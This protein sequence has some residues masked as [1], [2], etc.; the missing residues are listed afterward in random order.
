MAG[1][2]TIPVLLA[3][4][5]C[6]PVYYF[7]RIAVHNTVY[8]EKHE[9]FIRQTYR[10]RCMILGANGP[11]SLVIPVEHK[12]RENSQIGE[13]RI[14]YHTD[15]QRNHWRAI[16]SA[17]GNSPFFP[18]YADDIHDYYTRKWT[19][20]FDYNQEYLLT[21]LTLLKLHKELILTGSFEEVPEPFVNLREKISPK[22]P[23][24]RWSPGYSFLPYTQVFNDK[25]PF[26]GELSILDLLFNE[27]P[28][29]AENLL[30]P[31][32]LS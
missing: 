17:Y 9:S 18:Y 23:V 5:Y 26:V 29:A 20:L 1:T 4:T 8:I 28:L 27:G 31:D 14:A 11:L 13:V 19:F 2:D 3:T 32:R 21:I 25:F 6:G 10:N 15:W 12:G 24:S 7:S 30:L 22:I 16:F